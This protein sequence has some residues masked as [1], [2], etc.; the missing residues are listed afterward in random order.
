MTK[1]LQQRQWSSMIPAVEPVVARRRLA[2]LVA[3]VPGRPVDVP[4]GHAERVRTAAV[5]H[6]GRSR[7]G[8]GSG[9]S[10]RSSTLRLPATLPWASS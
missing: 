4:K 1:T 10:L 5:T 6:V 2:V 8:G 7:T 3:F 9:M